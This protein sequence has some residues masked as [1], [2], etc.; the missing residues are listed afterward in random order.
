MAQRTSHDIIIKAALA[1]HSR[2]IQ[3]VDDRMGDGC[4]HFEKG[5]TA[6]HP[7]LVADAVAV[8]DVAGFCDPLTLISAQLKNHVTPDT[9]FASPHDGLRRFGSIT[10]KVRPEYL[11]LLVLQLRCG[12]LRLASRCNGGASVFAV[13]KPGGT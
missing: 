9:I 11:A 6:Q 7:D 8:P 2:L 10:G 1:L 3:C 5:G 12:M 13:G 4:S